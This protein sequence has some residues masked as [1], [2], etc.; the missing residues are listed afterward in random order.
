MITNEAGTPAVSPAPTLPATPG[1][2]PTSLGIS[3]KME[4]EGAIKMLIAADHN[5]NQIVADFMNVV[6]FLLHKRAEGEDGQPTRKKTKGYINADDVKALL[7]V[8]DSFIKHF[9]DWATK[10]NATEVLADLKRPK[11]LL[12]LGAK[13]RGE[14]VSGQPKNT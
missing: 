5:M 9:T 4:A 10:V 11:S 6:A 12:K 8:D 1:A 7:D 14:A 13:R 3:S 2:A